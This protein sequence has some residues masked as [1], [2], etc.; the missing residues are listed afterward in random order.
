ASR[1][2]TV[3]SPAS[4]SNHG[5]LRS[6]GEKN[7]P[8]RNKTDNAGSTAPRT[9]LV[10]IEVAAQLLSIGRTTVYDLVNRG[11][12]RSTKIGRRTLVSVEDIDAFV[13]RILAS[14]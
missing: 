2:E 14:T 5:H 6:E 4:L 9:R 10:S 3:S 7:N 1:T 11:E 13:D 8:V 12:L